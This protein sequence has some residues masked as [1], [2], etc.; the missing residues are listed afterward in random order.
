MVIEVNLTIF[1]LLSFFWKNRVGLWDHVGIRVC[2]SVYPPINFLTPE[3]TF[4]KLGMYV[5]HGTWGHLN[6]LIK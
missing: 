1:S 4:M 2:V 5:Y 3:P 6:G